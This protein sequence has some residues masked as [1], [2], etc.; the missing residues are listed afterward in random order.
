MKE[1]FQLF[2]LKLQAVGLYELAVVRE[3]DWPVFHFNLQFNLAVAFFQ[4]IRE[5]ETTHS[6]SHSFLHAELMEQST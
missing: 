5:L 6:T 2:F 4:L 1:L 3:P